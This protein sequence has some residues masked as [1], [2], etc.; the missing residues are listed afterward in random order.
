MNS[1]QCF[2]W[3]ITTLNRKDIKQLVA[4]RNSSKHHAWFILPHMCGR[5]SLVQQFLHQL[6]F[7]GY[8]PLCHPA[9][10]SQ[11]SVKNRGFVPKVLHNSTLNSAALIERDSSAWPF[12]ARQSQHHP[13][14]ASVEN[15]EPPLGKAEK[16]PYTRAASAEL[17]NCTTRETE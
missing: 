3:G 10:E 13:Q 9:T 16:G 8:I 17:T 2:C 11:A 14:K 6:R 1:L 15:T 7:Q 4:N 12:T 5:L